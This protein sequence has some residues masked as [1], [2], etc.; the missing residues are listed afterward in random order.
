MQ[1]AGVTVLVVEDEPIIRFA[2]VDALEEKGYR[3]LEASNV[4]EA[5]GVIGKNEQIAA[6]VT[7]IDMPGGLSGLDLVET[8]DKSQHHIAVVVT[9]GGHASESLDLPADARFFSKPYHFDDIFFA[10]RSAI[11]AK[12]RLLKKRRGL[13]LVGAAAR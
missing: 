11:A 3:V 10:V 6:V 9:S 4:L 7:D 8:L 13:R 12:A 5:V 1:E 2:L